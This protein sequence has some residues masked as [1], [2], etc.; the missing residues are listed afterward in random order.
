MSGSASDLLGTAQA[1]DPVLMAEALGV[2]LDPWQAA[3]LRSAAARALV[4]CARQSGKTL[5]AALLALHLLVFRPR[6]LVLALSPAQRQSAELVRR[7]RGYYYLLQDPPPL[8]A[9]GVTHL[10]LAN[11]SRILALPGSEQTVRGFAAVNLL[12]LDEASRVPDALFNSLRPMLA[13]SKGRLLAL[14]T[15]AGRRGWFHAAWAGD[16]DWQRVR[17]V[18]SECPRFTAQFL[19]RERAEMGPRWYR[20]E[21]E[22]SFEDDAGCP[23]D[24]NLVRAAFDPTVRPLFPAAALPRPAYAVTS[25]LVEALFGPG[26]LKEV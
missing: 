16:E 22:C 24:M 14:S 4:L 25:D 19:A 3:L 18:G 21:Y 11:G 17:V 12:L 20:Q 2:R 26:G 23:F 7:V 15:P 6:S 5:A 9:L 1:L 10:E 13:V 8:T